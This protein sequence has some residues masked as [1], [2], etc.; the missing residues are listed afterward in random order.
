MPLVLRRGPGW[1]PI[2]FMFVAAWMHGA[3]HFIVASIELLGGLI[4][5]L[6]LDYVSSQASGISMT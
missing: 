1:L 4:Q 5:P 2:P 6:I 3:C